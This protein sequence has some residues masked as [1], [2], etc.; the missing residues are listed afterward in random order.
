VEYQRRFYT[1]CKDHWAGPIGAYGFSEFIRAATAAGVADYTHVAGA[2]DTVL[3]TDTFWQ[4]NNRKDYPGGYEV[5]INWQYHPLEGHTT[6]FTPQQE[7]AIV[8][9]A[10][11]TTAIL[12]ELIGPWPSWVPGSDPKTSARSAVAWLQTIDANIW[13]MS[14]VVHTMSAALAAATANPDITEQQIKTIFEQALVSHIDGTLSL[15]IG[16]SPAP[17]PVAPSQN[18]P[19]PPAA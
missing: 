13:N 5:D 18:P 7:A 17:V 15:H 11:D 4:E 1:T 16:G 14:A 12:H 8:Q 9:A 3:A 10:A 19:T 6:M 2:A